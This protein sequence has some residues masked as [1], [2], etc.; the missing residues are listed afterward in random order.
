ME[1]SNNQRQ[2]CCRRGLSFV[3]FIGCL[4]SMIGGVL[5]GSF[6]L[7]LDA[8]KVAVGVLEQAQVVAPGYFSQFVKPAAVGPTGDTALTGETTARSSEDF[9]ATESAA[10]NTP[11]NESQSIASN[12]EPEPSAEEMQQAT[13]AYW[14]ELTVIMLSEVQNRVPVGGSSEEW[15][16]YDY[17]S[18][19]QRG[20]EQA[21][22]KLEQ[23][24]GLG[25]DERLLGHTEQ[26]IEWHKAGIKKF[27]EALSLM[28][29]GPGTKLSGPL[30]Q[31][32]QSA[33]TQ[34]R[35]EESLIVER[36]KA[37]AN[38]LDREYVS[39]APFIPAFQ[40]R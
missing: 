32:W 19:R 13:R 7:G 36:H 39:A 6:Y 29:D 37:V 28:S 20:H 38:Y 3:E 11:G 21:L 33:I 30:A 40:P 15:E 27:A 34:L 16:L 4:V 12:V 9:A 5:I 1:F 31:R 8:Q 25:V 14:D 23:L 24:D 22:A 10:A 26:V 35:M 18:Q 2:A 17:L